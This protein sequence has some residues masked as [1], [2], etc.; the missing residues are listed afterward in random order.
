VMFD[1]RSKT[2]SEELTVLSEATAE[3][4]KGAVPNE[5]ANKKLVGL[6][7]K[8]AVV[9]KAAVSP[10]AV[11]FV[12]IN[13]VKFE[14]SRKAVVVQKV[15]DL[16]HGAAG[17]SGSSTLANAA[18]RVKM[19]EDHFVKVRALI[20][21]LI[22]KLEADA[23]AEADQKSICD[24]GMKAAIKDRDEANANIELASA[25][26]TSLS[27][28]IEELK[29]NINQL[30]ADIAAAKKALL[31]ATELRNEDKEDHSTTVSMSEEAIESVKL[32]MGLLQDFYKK[33]LLAQ[34]GKYTPPNADRSGKTVGDLAPEVF[35]DNYHGSQSE[36]KGIIGI[37]EV[38]LSDFERTKKTTESDEKESKEA[39]EQLEKETNDDIE[40]KEGSIK[41]KEGELSDA[42][43]DLIEQ[44]SALSDAQ[45]LLESSKGKLE[46]LEVMC[47]K[48]EETW[49]ERKKKRE[50]E[51]EAL[52][53][54]LETLE[55][56]Q[57]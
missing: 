23:K 30:N 47:V 26:I 38:I 21:D 6:Q 52:K 24:K 28:K 56:W 27:A 12:Q 16:L 31:E 9:H 34:T 51:I 22:A 33:A 46:S 39:F 7:K 3:L 35:D 1:Q 17:R 15:I 32:A 43:S 44:Q 4:E 10:T 40:K 19:S 37:L 5:S 18:M 55:N 20:K 50:D 29:S 13:N 42:K 45:E 41:K 48:G 11:S 49:E 54:A 57:G 53:T 36:S 14:Q 25:K 2:R 8:P